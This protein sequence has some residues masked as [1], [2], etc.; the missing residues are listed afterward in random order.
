[1]SSQE[2]KDVK[3]EFDKLF[4]Y[5][6]KGH[7]KDIRYMTDYINKGENLTKKPIDLGVIVMN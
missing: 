6:I 1:M 4:N 5:P 3:N 7:S 2:I